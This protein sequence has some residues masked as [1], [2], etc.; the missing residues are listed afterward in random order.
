MEKKV[1]NGGDVDELME[2]LPE[3]FW[4][5]GIDFGGKSNPIKQELEGVGEI[6]AWNDTYSFDRRGG[7]VENIRFLD[8]VNENGRP[9]VIES[10]PSGD[11]WTV[12]TDI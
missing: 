8:I 6:E 2:L 10:D 1:F 7:E 12:R 5:L 3:G 11:S 9:V 4:D